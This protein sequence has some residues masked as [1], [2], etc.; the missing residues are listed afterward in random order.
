MTA[1]LSHRWK[2]RDDTLAPAVEGHDASLPFPLVLHRRARAAVRVHCERAL[3]RISVLAA[4]DVVALLGLRYTL[5]GVGDR[6]WLGN[7]VAVIVRS[8]LHQGLLPSTQLL[9]AVALGL[10]L[11]GNYGQGDLRRNPSRVFGGVALGVCLVVWASIW[12]EPSISSLVGCGLAILTLG[13]AVTSERALLEILIRRLRPTSRHAARTLIVGCAPAARKA[14]QSPAFA[15]SSEFVILGYVD[16]QHYPEADALGGATDLVSLI[17]RHKVDTVVFTGGLDDEI[18][19]RMV[20]LVEAAGCSAISLPAS[21]S[22]GG[23]EP[24]LQW[25]RG[26]P[27]LQLTRPALRGWQ[28]VAKRVID[29]T[30]ALLV[31]ALLAPACIC[32]AIAIKLTSSGPVIF[33]QLR[34]G[35]G[36]RRFWIYKFRTMVRDAEHRQRDI[37]AQ[38]LYS[39]GR[40]FK[41]PD[42]PRVTRIGRFLRRT[43]LDE[44]PQLINVLRG[45]MSL[46][47]PRPPLPAEVEHYDE[48]HY[49]RFSMRP[50]ITGP[51]QVNGRNRITDFEQV[52]SLETAYMRCWSIW[53][54]V[55]IMLRTLPVVLRMDGAH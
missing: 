40:L 45:E 1:V 4:A 16:V 46:V 20:D 2:K 51:W 31:L 52:V 47:G 38:S 14:R 11:F 12:H 53:K 39:D 35:A 9:V 48:H 25:R 41:I 32:I 28:L 50:G 10:L 22:T 33:R 5:R 36:G 26:V 29:L 23:L 55:E 21:F 49:A 7:R 8:T 24:R 19:D 54:D 30:G 42:D 27:F 3:A 15:D 6:G 34:V 44:L 18:L 17:G 37:A 43:S 13:V